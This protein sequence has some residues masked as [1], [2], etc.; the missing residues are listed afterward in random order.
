MRLC[1]KPVQLFYWLDFKIWTNHRAEPWLV[2]ES[3][4]EYLLTLY[5]CHWQDIV[6]GMLRYNPG[7]IF[8]PTSQK[9]QRERRNKSP[10]S[11]VSIKL[12]FK[13][14]IKKISSCEVSFNSA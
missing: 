2:T 7:L 13:V 5:T 14:P 1:L 6:L 3:L 11:E 4:L 8:F 12:S 10:G 9:R